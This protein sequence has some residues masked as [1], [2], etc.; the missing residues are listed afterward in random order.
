MASTKTK[1]AEVP[2]P[3]SPKTELLPRDRCDTCNAQAFVRTSNAKGHILDW[4]GHH[5]NK[6]EATLIGQG[7]QP[8]IDNREFINTKPSPSATVETFTETNLPDEEWD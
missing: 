7:F 5:F 2:E 1:V 8:E 4:C 3:Q 6:F